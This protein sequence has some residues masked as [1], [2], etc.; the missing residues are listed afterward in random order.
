MRKHRLARVTERVDNS[1]RR[2]EISHRGKAGWR[3]C[4]G[5]GLLIGARENT[6]WGRCGGK[7][8]RVLLKERWSGARRKNNRMIQREGREKKENNLWPRTALLW[9]DYWGHSGLSL[10]EFTH[11]HTHTHIFL[12]AWGFIKEVRTGKCSH[13]KDFHDPVFPLRTFVLHKCTN[14]THTQ[15]H[16]DLPILP[17]YSSHYQW[18]MKTLEY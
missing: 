13:L 11:K 2:R 5:G 4:E 3:G 16:A 14:T 9:R 18:P 10:A 6:D 1:E 15:T 12:C 8:Q 17:N 7:R